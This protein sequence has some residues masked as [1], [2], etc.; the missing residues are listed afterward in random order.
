[1]KLISTAVKLTT[2]I[3][4]FFGYCFKRLPYGLNAA[5]QYFMRRMNQVLEGLEGLVCQVDYILVY[6][7]TEVEQD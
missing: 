6:G 5:P 4:P 1:M 3:T 7:E 2:F